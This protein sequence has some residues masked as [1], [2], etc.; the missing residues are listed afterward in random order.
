MLFS[1]YPC[2][3]PHREIYKGYVETG[4]GQYPIAETKDWIEDMG[5]MTDKVKWAAYNGFLF[6]SV[7][8]YMDIR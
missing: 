5:S 3:T 2:V 4:P 7:F 6:S 1:K 8:S